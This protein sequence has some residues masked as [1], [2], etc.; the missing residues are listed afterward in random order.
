MLRYGHDYVDIRE[1][2][3]EARFWQ[4]RL[5]TL[6]HNAKALGYTVVPLSN[7]A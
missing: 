4:R 7:A 5:A 6:R 1:V 3:Y 2:Q